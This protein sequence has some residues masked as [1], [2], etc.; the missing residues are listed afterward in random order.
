MPAKP[1][2]EEQLQDARRLSEAFDRAKDRDPSLTQESLAHSCGWK[3]QGTVSQYMRGKIP[4]NMAAL[5]KFCEALQSMP[6]EISPQIAEKLKITSL[7][8]AI[9]AANLANL[10]AKASLGKSE[11]S[12]PDPL[13]SPSSDSKSS[14]PGARLDINVKPVPL[15]LRV[16]PVISYVQA[17]ELTEISDPYEMGDGFAI[18]MCEDDLGPST[19]ALEIE[20][21]S[22]LPEFRPGDRIIVDPDV[23]PNPGNFVVAKNGN[24]E[25]TFKKYRPRGT[26]EDGRP[27]FELTPLNDDYPTLRSDIDQLRIIGTMVEHR[28]KYRRS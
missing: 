23:A 13:L 5:L 6:E 27:V 12:S 2:T 1:L 16:I 19:F 7:D 11:V 14:A 18:E 9:S 20:G 22:M 15:G 3:T 25:A 21:D 28:K 24:Q 8:R 17:G 4:L 10:K 26:G